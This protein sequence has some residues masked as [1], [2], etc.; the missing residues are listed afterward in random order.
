MDPD[1]SPTMAV[2]TSLGF[3]A[4]QFPLS[5]GFR[6]KNGLIGAVPL[7]GGTSLSYCFFA[8]SM[9]FLQIRPFLLSSSN[10]ASKGDGKKDL[11]KIQKIKD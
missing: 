5:V 4:R 1:F 3:L 6:F 11:D 9:A 8:R 10:S 7:V 2:T